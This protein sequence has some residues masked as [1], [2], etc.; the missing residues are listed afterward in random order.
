MLAHLRK[1]LGHAGRAGEVK[2][3]VKQNSLTRFG[4]V[5]QPHVRKLNAPESERDKLKDC[6][7]AIEPA[8]LCQ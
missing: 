8:G 6:C 7:A 2:P 1:S 4:P 5:V 3:H